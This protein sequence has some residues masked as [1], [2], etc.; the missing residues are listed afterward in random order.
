MI[1]GIERRKIFLDNKDR[2]DL[3][4]RLSSLLP[5]TETS[6]YAWAFL[7]NHAHF[8]FR[9][10]LIPLATLMRRLLTGYVVR[11]NRRHK[12]TGHLFQNRY[13]SIVC[14]EEVYLEELVRYI[15]LNPI[16][17]KIVSSLSVLNKYAYC[18][19]SVIM[20]R[21]DRPW[22][23]VD[24]VL[25]YFGKTPGRAKKAYYSYVEAGLKQG[26]RK[27]L[28]G[29]GLI[30]SLGG[31]AEVSKF[32]LKGQGHIKSDERILGESD[33]VDDI[34]S[35]A[36]EKF[37][38]SYELKRLGYDLDRIALRVAEIFKIEVKDIFLKGKHQKRVKPRSLFCYWAVRELGIPLTELARL[39]VISVPAVGY[40]V[41]RG[42]ILA[43]ENDYQLRILES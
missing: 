37:E 13:K 4:D 28:T 40:S 26:R 17:A 10:G 18:G 33:F 19:H 42:E 29:G 31:W 41:E 22:L 38:R 25:S 23:D 1:R 11:F 43:K 15:H 14:Q 8:L 6:C 16:R 21:K 32:G 3:L 5:E 2:E 20:G 9:T 7:Q 34:L 30:R 36:S 24:Y 35:L 12:R 27:E 39:L